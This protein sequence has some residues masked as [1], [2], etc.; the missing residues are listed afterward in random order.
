MND[1]PNLQKEWKEFL[2]TILFLASLLASVLA[3]WV[4]SRLGG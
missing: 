4:M 3:M 1:E 2:S